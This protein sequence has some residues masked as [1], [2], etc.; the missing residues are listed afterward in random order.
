VVATRD[1]QAAHSSLEAPGTELIR[2]AGRTLAKLQRGPAPPRLAVP[3][4]QTAL[5]VIAP[6]IVG[7]A[8]LT[9]LVRRKRLEAMDLAVSMRLQA[10]RHP[11]LERAMSFV[12]WFGFP[13]QSRL[14]PPLLI[15]TLWLA[16]FRLEAAFQ[17][18]SWGSALI[19]SVIKRFMQRPRPAA[20][21]DLRVVAAKLGGS[22]FPSGHVLTYVGTY[23]WLAVIANILI[24]QPRPRR[25][26]LAGLLTLLAG[27]GPSR[28][29]LGHH[30]PSDVAASYLLGTSYVAVLV[31]AYRRLKS[32]RVLQ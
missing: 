31:I 18:A 8:A 3:R 17:L 14:L 13:P 29:Y 30:W 7:F 15:S 10:I 27:V 22:S 26:V 23:G 2:E 5:R 28:I 24:V 1:P 4:T 19:S 12:S 21:T 32:R 16:R 11:F 6:G 20:G 25:A 9:A